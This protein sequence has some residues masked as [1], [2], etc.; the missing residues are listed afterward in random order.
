MQPM[1]QEHFEKNTMYS[2]SKNSSMN[3]SVKF[4]K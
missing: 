3:M 1:L 2:I 4:E